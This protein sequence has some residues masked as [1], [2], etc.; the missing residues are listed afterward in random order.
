MVRFFSSPQYAGSHILIL[1][2]D[3][4]VKRSAPQ[5]KRSSSAALL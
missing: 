2:I 1:E 5:V 3:V 4:F